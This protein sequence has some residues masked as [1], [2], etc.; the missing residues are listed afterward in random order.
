MHGVAKFAPPELNHPTHVVVLPGGGVV[1]AECATSELLH[2]SAE[3]GML[4]TLGAR[5]AGA[6]EVS[7]PRG[8]A[9]DGEALFVADG[10]NGRVQ[11]RWLTEPEV[12]SNLTLTLTER[13]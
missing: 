12:Q 1:V 13:A 10:G 2:L 6:S 5:G 3:G 4:G 11:K 8:L 7:A 9:C